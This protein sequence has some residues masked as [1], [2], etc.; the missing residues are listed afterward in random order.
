LKIQTQ[1][2]EVAT[3]G[4]ACGAKT[5]IR[6]APSS[7]PPRWSSRA[8]ASEIAVPPITMAALK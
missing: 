5:A 4:V 1:A 2:S 8:M 3:M 6:V 7:R